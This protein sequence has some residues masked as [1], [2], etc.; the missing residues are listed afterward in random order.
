MVFHI[1]N[2][3]KPNP[4]IIEKLCQIHENQENGYRYIYLK[5]VN[6]VQP[7]FDKEKILCVEY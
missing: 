5:I 3:L 4:G 1:S 7:V 2:L 6:D